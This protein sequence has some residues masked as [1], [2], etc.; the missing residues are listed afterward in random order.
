MNYRHK[1]REEKKTWKK[2]PGFL[3]SPDQTKT[4]GVH[5]E[6]DLFTQSVWV[7][8][9]SSA[10]QSSAMIL[11]DDVIVV[12]KSLKSKPMCLTLVN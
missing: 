5:L 1:R 11:F 12:R 9:H 7:L 3:W 4:G 10:I 8:I 2:N 6:G